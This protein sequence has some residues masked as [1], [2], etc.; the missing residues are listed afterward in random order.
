MSIPKRK[1]ILTQRVSSRK[2]SPK[3]SL[4]QI[5]A[6]S[7]FQQYL[8]MG[9][10]LRHLLLQQIIPDSLRNKLFQP[11]TVPTNV[12]AT[13]QPVSVFVGVCN[14]LDSQSSSIRHY[15]GSL[16]RLRLT[17][18]DTHVLRYLLSPREKLGAS[19]SRDEA[20]DH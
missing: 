11:G 20:R 13:E 18:S 19:E 17:Y 8:Q 10:F 12:L 6:I 3:W 15:N 7:P 5:W 16:K 1:K 14:M 4:L 9:T 2:L